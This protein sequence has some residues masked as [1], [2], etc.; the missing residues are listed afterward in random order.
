MERSEVPPFTRWSIPVA[1][2]A[3]ALGAMPGSLA[4]PAS[5][6]RP[7]APVALGVDVADPGKPPALADYV[8]A[9]GSTP[10]IV[11]WFQSFDEPLYYDDQMSAVDATG[12][13][14]MISW[15]PARG[16]NG[17]PLTDLASGEYDAYL[18]TAAAAAAAWRSRSSSASPRK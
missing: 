15:A 13:I 7:E 18:R 3:A 10:A 9:A 16:S 4:R 5:A 11:G 14:P 12:A 6:A 1:L 2:V 8:S 17:I